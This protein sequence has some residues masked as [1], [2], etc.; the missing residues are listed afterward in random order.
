MNVVVWFSCGAAS[1]VAAKL[2]VEKYGAENVRVVNTP[3]KEEHEDNAR[4]LRD[5]AKWIG[6]DIEFATNP[7]YPENS[8]VDVWDDKRFMSSV[9]G[10]PCTLLLKKMARR[11]WEEKNSVQKH[12]FG[13]TAE[14][15][16][17]HKNL[18]QRED[19]SIDP[20][21]IDVGITKQDCLDMLVLAGIEIPEMYKLG[22]PNNNCIGCVKATSPTYWNHV[23]KTHPEIFTERVEQS[24]EIGARLVRHKG[25]RVFLD[26]L[27]EDAVGAPLKS[28]K[29]DCG[30][31]C[32]KY[33]EIVE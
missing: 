12:V 30:L 3:I 9:R 27:P 29:F 23:R 24:R 6:K 17:R 2:A 7:A 18:S 15:G 14:E 28:L 1:A 13:F 31:L 5:V 20:I 19:I 22:Y 21:L 25:V 10:A 4:F 33:K 11:Q 32:E 26:E 16:H 8:A